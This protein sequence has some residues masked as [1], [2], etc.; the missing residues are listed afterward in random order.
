MAVS[1]VFVASVSLEIT[2]FVISYSKLAQKKF[3]RGGSMGMK[4]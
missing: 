1:P 2:D 4:K 3:S